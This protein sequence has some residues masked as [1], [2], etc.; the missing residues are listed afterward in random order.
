M[1]Q[2]DELQDINTSNE[3]EDSLVLEDSKSDQAGRVSA[4]TIL[5]AEWS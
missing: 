4:G 1:C 5:S 2:T 3:R